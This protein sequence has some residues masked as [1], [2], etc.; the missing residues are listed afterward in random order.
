MHSYLIF[1]VDLKWRFEK[2]KCSTQ[3]TWSF[4]CIY[5]L[6]IFVEKKNS[7]I[8]CLSE[9]VLCFGGGSG[10]CPNRVHQTGESAI[11]IDR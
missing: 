5:F 1:G 4:V 10:A 6:F 3:A 9:L 7:T 2:L 11:R 8:N